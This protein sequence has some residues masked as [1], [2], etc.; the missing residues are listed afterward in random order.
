MLNELDIGH[1]GHQVTE[2]DASP[3][4][5][6][7]P[8]IDWILFDD[9]KPNQIVLID[10]K[11]HQFFKKMDEAGPH[12]FMSH[13]TG[14]TVRLVTTRLIELCDQSRYYNPQRVTTHVEKDCIDETRA[15]IGKVYNTINAGPRARGAVI[16]RYVGAFINK[17]LTAPRGEPFYRNHKNAEAVIIQVDK[18]IDAEN[19]QMP[20]GEK[21]IKKPKKCTRT[22]LRWLANEL[23]YGMQERTF[24]HKNAIKARG[25]K[26]PDQVFSVVQ[27][28]IRDLV[29]LSAE[30]GP[31]KIKMVANGKI[32]ELNGEIRLRNKEIQKLIESG[33]LT[34][35][36]L[37]VEL[38]QVGLSTV[39]VGYRRYDAWIRFAKEHGAQ[40]A[41]L[42]FGGEG[43]FKRPDHIL[44]EVE[45][46]H[47]EFDFVG[48]LGQT[49]FGQVWSRAG[50]DRFWICLGLDVHSGYPVGFFPSFE[51]GGLYPALAALDHA[52]KV[53]TY[54][55]RRFPQIRGSLL[56][57]GKPRKVRYDNGKEFVSEQMSLAL[58]RVRIG[59]E[60]AVPHRPDTKP[61]V[62]RFFGTL[63]QDFVSWLKGSTG[64]SPQHR[65]ARKP[66]LDACITIDDF[67]FLFHL[68]LIEVYAR[69]KQKGLDWHSPEE[70]WLRGMSSP[71]HR[72][73]L[74]TKEELS[75]WDLIPCLELD[76]KAGKDGI[77]W[78]NLVYQSPQLQEMRTRSGYTGKRKNKLTPVKVRI[79]LAN[80]GRCIVAD[81]TCLDPGNEHLP[82]E[83]DVDATD[84]ESHGLTKFQW[85][86]LCKLRNAQK[87]APTEHPSHEVGFNH[88]LAEALK[89][90]GMVPADQT[91]PKK[92]T[93][94]NGVYPRIAGVLGRGAEDH[95]LA[96]TEELIE[97]TG[98]FKTAA[99]E[100][101]TISSPPPVGSTLSAE[102]SGEPARKKLRFEVDA[103]L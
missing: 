42:E 29:D 85:D 94:S 88:L 8:S 16:W 34:E 87:N 43:K 23:K 22:M 99:K 76:L 92:A 55:A 45:L 98:L 2:P 25:R 40:A 11:P 13:H 74:P 71:K 68:W 58:A 84:K 17:M 5:T 14:E 3:A 60:F 33:D 97:K 37:L 96:V 64:S 100:T 47:H 6:P 54:V 93:L 31:T 52:I 65:G 30:F 41:D 80:V 1:P 79:P 63:E 102:K 12:L 44:D 32:G 24:V 39:T 56:S 77:R 91:P 48:V 10:D 67:I 75:K 86:A 78:N 53:K 62:E 57:F 95:A 28:T 72:P 103:P 59:F 51:P 4:E 90:M 38:P 82:P 26:L 81:P 20:E 73:Q 66:L 69:R 19:L 36:A 101:E 49:P 61:F 70:C 46:D 83:F 15:Q 35:E 89:A 7:V 21:L 50:I 27:T 18:Q 9:L